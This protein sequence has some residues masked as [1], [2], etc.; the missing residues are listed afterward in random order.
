MITFDE[1]GK[2]KKENESYQKNCRERKK[3]IV[4]DPTEKTCCI[5]FSNFYFNFSI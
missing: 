5:Y 4:E 3:K 1:K 2:T